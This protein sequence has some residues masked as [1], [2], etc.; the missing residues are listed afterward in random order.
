MPP[1]EWGR[2]TANDLHAVLVGRLA[3]LRAV[4]NSGPLSPD[5]SAAVEPVTRRTGWHHRSVRNRPPATCAGPSGRERMSFVRTAH[6]AAG[7]TP[8][9]A[10]Y[11]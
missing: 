10:A 11:T 1:Q 5:W 9:N 3:A 7:R 8:A 2:A 4:P 6:P